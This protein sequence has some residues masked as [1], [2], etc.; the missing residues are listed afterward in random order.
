MK[1]GPSTGGGGGNASRILQYTVSP[2]VRERALFL[3]VT[4]QGAKV[5][6]KYQI[7][8]AKGGKFHVRYKRSHQFRWRYI[9]G[10]AN[11]VAG[12][13]SQKIFAKLHKARSALARLIE[14]HHA[15]QEEKKDKKIAYEISYKSGELPSELPNYLKR[16]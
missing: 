11:A 12:D 6:T 13:R 15:E 16:N 9:L 10:G 7:V 3:P 14:C 2:T 1:S 8:R 5:S 4:F